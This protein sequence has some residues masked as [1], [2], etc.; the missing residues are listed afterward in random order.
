MNQPD[1]IAGCILGTACGDAL[2]LP[3]EAL[4]RTRGAKLLG[5]PDRYRFIVRHG[6]V[7]DDTEHTCM[8]AQALIASQGDPDR[9][10]ASF[11][12]R[13]RWWLLGLPAGIGGATLRSILKLWLSFPPHHSGVHSAGNGPAMRSAI[14]GACFDDLKLIQQFSN[15]ATT[16]THRDQRAIDGAL[17]IAVAAWCARLHNEISPDTF[18]RELRE[19]IH[20]PKSEIMALAKRAVQSIELCEDTQQFA[21]TLGLERGVTGYIC[22]TVPV[23]IHAWLSHSTDWMAAVQS[24][25]RCGGDTDTT[26]AIVGALVG[27]RGGVEG[28]P[29][30]LRTQLLEW[31]RS[32][33]WMLRLADRL[34]QS[35][36]SPQPVQTI[37]LPPLT[38]LPRNVL[39]IL[40]VMLH[41]L[42]RC[43]PPY[44]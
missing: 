16:I 9:F 15:A 34:A 24:V 44:G 5:P 41:L 20:D 31:P 2:G 23:C 42:R 33:R 19:C 35:M 1:A 39:F 12:W 7:S 17:A 22:H 10:A 37:E 28:I 26:A 3:Y 14:F 21:D 36:Q 13:L 32:D 4:S 38:I 27:T 43:L 6:M 8:V 29:A 30:H 18:L 25:I 11:A 40:V